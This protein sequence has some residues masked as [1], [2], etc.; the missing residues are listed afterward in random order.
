MVLLVSSVYFGLA[1]SYLDISSV[2]F[3]RSMTTCLLS[4]IRTILRKISRKCWCMRVQLVPGCFSPSR[5]GYKATHERKWSASGEHT[6][7]HFTEVVGF[8][9]LPTPQHWPIDPGHCLPRPIKNERTFIPVLHEER[10]GT[11]S[12]LCTYHQLTWRNKEEMILK[13]TVI[14]RCQNSGTYL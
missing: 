12:T 2:F 10:G 9:Q 4:V 5:P 14:A 8:S 3:F 1:N 7:R 6:K 13:C 11:I